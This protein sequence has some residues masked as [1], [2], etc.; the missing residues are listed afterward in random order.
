MFCS[1]LKEAATQHD[2]YA[3]ASDIKTIIDEVYSSATDGEWILSPSRFGKRPTAVLKTNSDGGK[4]FLKCLDS[5]C[6]GCVKTP[7]SS[8]S[9]FL[10]DIT[11]TTV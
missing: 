1:H 3:S 10:R 4:P 9:A 8:A 5:E 7:F 11:T 6:D 2:G